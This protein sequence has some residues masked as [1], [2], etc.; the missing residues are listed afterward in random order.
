MS[1]CLLK[2]II[3]V[4]G[5][6]SSKEIQQWPLVKHCDAAIF[7]EVVINRYRIR[8]KNEWWYWSSTLVMSLR[9]GL[10]VI[11]KKKAMAK[12]TLSSRLV[13]L[14]VTI[15]LSPSRG[16]ISHSDGNSIKPLDKVFKCSPTCQL[17]GAFIFL[18]PLIA[19]SIQIH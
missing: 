3:E 11:Q 16:G 13:S 19:N 8:R 1:G 12:V 18:Q 9:W 15:F 17:C 2:W 5:M 10:D 7:G 6:W 14:N 4:N